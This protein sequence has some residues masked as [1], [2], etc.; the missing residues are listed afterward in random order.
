M[1]VILDTNFLM[2]VSQ[3]K[4]DVFLQ[5]RGSSIF[6]TD[7]II[8]ELE[9]FSNGSSKKAMSARMALQLIKTKGLKVLKPK[10]RNVDKSLTL[11]SFK[12]YVIA[13]QDRELRENI[14]RAGGKSIY[15]R[16]KKYVIL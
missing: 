16:Q 9:G 13:T 11:Y 14:K 8:K 7:S 10:E 6:V 15:I 3:F 12:G 1:K 5:L 2:A 4:I